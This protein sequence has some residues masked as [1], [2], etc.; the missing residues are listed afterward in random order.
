MS[1]KSSCGSVA[2]IFAR[3]SSLNWIGSPLILLRAL[4][5]MA[6]SPHALQRIDTSGEIGMEITFLYGMTVFCG[7]ALVSFLL[8]FVLPRWLRRRRERPNVR[9]EGQTKGAAFWLS[10]RPT[11]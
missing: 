9:G 6:N 2:L 1:K 7:S 8:T 10:P 4:S 3:Q 11:G 5:E